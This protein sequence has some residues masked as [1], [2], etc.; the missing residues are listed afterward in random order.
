MDLVYRFNQHSVAFLSVLIQSMSQARLL[1][2]LMSENWIVNL[3]NVKSLKLRRY[4][5]VWQAVD[6]IALLEHILSDRWWTR[7]WTYH[8][9]FCASTKM[10][11]VMLCHKSVGKDQLYDFQHVPG[12]LCL[13]AVE[14]RAQ[15]TRFYLVYMWKQ[16]RQ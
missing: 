4:V 14:I 13:S 10:V 7:A 5:R 3:K 6:T 2:K 11:L 1:S 15:L 8:N 12:E 16:G 9:E